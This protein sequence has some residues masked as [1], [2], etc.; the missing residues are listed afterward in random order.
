MVLHSPLDLGS[1]G[2]DP[3]PDQCD[4]KRL[5]GEAGKEKKGNMGN[6]KSK[7]CHEKMSFFPTNV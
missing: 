5:K 2:A 7:A 6:Q 3:G 4:S 1:D